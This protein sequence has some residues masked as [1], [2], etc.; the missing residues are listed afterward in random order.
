[1]SEI[2]IALHGKTQD[3][4]AYQ[5]LGKEMSEVVQGSEPDTIRYDWYLSPDGHTLNIDGYTSSE[6]FLAHM[7]AASASGMLDKWMSVVEVER[8]EVKGEPSADARAALEGFGAIFLDKFLSVT[9]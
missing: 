4:A 6:A 9:R 2:T 5:A 1:M 7:G 8:V 3:P